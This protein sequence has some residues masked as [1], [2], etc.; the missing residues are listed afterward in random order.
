MSDPDSAGGKIL[1]DRIGIPLEVFHDCVQESV[2]RIKALADVSV[3]WRGKVEIYFTTRLVLYTVY[4]V[5][6]VLVF[7]PLP[8]ASDWPRVRIPALILHAAETRG[9]FG[10]F[11][12]EDV[13]RLFLKDAELV[14]E[15][16]G[17][18]QAG[19]PKDRVI[20]IFPPRYC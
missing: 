14:Y 8:I 2:R 4:R 7:A 11:V 10:G 16:K 15:A 12:A 18:R 3:A 1:A 6:N 13:S 9:G 5:D 19:F 20:F 17:K